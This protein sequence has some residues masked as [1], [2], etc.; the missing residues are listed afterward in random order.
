MRKLYGFIYVWKL[1]GTTLAIHSDH[2]SKV[3][4]LVY[5]FYFNF[6]VLSFSESHVSILK[7]LDFYSSNHITQTIPSPWETCVGCPSLYQVLGM[8]AD[9]YS[10]QLPYIFLVVGVG[11][12]CIRVQ[13]H[14][15]GR[16]VCGSSATCV[17]GGCELPD[18]AAWYW[19]WVLWK[20]RM[21][22]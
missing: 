18:M 4:F 10:F 14:K 17:S 8:L 19:T 22:F 16:W 6:G 20:S 3:L 2:S 12:M 11:V 7:H 13:I 15:E 1:E 5:L 21:W 9:S